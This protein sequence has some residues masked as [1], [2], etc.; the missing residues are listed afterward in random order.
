MAFTVEDGTQIIAA[1]AYATVAAVDAYLVDRGRE[2]ENNWHGI[3]S[4]VKEIAIVKATDYIEKRWGPRFRGTRKGSTAVQ[5]L[6]WPRTGAF[7]RNGFEYADDEIPAKLIQATAEYAV[8][9]AAGVLL[10]DPQAIGETAIRD[11]KRKTEKVGPIEDTTEYFGA[12]EAT[13][14]G[15]SPDVTPYPAADLLML[16]LVTGDPVGQNLIQFGRV[17]R[18]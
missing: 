11:I 13:I 5:G 16:E 14:S 8:R 1:N 6:E 9:A 7:D 2:A 17:V 15:L 12:G 18:A 3:T 10:A 4:T